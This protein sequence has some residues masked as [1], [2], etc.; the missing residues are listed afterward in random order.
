V[1]KFETQ[2]TRFERLIF[3]IRGV[4][5]TTASRKTTLE[6]ADINDVPV[7]YECRLTSIPD[8]TSH[9]PTPCNVFFA[10]AKML[11]TF[12][13]DQC[14]P[15]PQNQSLASPFNILSRKY[16]PKFGDLGSETS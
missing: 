6:P 7:E 15:I 1:P 5:K 9:S 3:N 2:D 13:A 10:G 16:I 8:F 14:F 12:S 4:R 11:A